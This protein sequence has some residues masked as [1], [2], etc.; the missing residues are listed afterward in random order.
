MV[1]GEDAVQE[2]LSGQRATETKA[3]ESVAGKSIGTIRG[4]QKEVGM[5]EGKSIKPRTNKI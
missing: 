3:T 1:A 4:I 2:G 5:H